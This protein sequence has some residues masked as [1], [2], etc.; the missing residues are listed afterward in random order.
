[1]KGA[2]SQ[3]RGGIHGFLV[4]LRIP[5]EGVYVAVLSNLTGA[6]PAPGLLAR[7]AAAIAIGKPLVNPAAIG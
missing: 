4:V 1:M 3:E 2:C 7:K 6:R 5:S